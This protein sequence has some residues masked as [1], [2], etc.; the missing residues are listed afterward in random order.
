MPEIKFWQ[1][2]LLSPLRQASASSAL[3]FSQ[4]SDCCFQKCEWSALNHLWL[5]RNYAFVIHNL[6]DT[7]PDHRDAGTTSGFC[8]IRDT[9]RGSCLQLFSFCLNTVIPDGKHHPPMMI[10]QDLI[11][12]THT[13]LTTSSCLSFGFIPFCVFIRGV[14]RQR[15]EKWL[16]KAWTQWNPEFIIPS[17][18]C[19][20]PTSCLVIQSAACASLP[21]HFCQRVKIYLQ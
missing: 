2:C 17:W 20:S 5:R 4:T 9:R 19:R 14:S 3:Q 7:F 18:V 13:Q 16:K 1:C 6:I 8:F 15:L 21:A 11:L 10:Y 12:D